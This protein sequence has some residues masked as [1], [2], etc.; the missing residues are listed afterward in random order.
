MDKYTA[1]LML[2]LLSLICLGNCASENE[3]LSNSSTLVNMT[4]AEH[5]PV[6]LNKDSIGIRNSSEHLEKYSTDMEEFQNIMFEY[7]ED[8]LNRDKI[9]I[10]PGVYIEKKASNTSSDKFEKKSLDESLVSTI[11][12]FTDKHVL[13]VELARA[14]SETGRLFFF[15][16]N[17]FSPIQ[18][19]WDVFRCQLN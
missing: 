2:L 16:G 15:K 8:V 9:N 6:I 17:E 10:M 3:I 18:Y 13:K 14:M 7:I 1:K 12:D 4:E 11:K 19:F 5:E